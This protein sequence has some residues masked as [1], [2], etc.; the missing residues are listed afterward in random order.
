MKHFDGFEAFDPPAAGSVVMVGNFDGV[1]RGHRRLVDAARRRA[2]R[3]AVPVVAV[4]FEPHPLSIIAPNRAPARLSTRDEKLTLLARCGV[5]ATIVLESDAAL[6]ARSALDFLDELVRRSRPR[7]IVEGPTFNFGRGR[8]GSVETL[9]QNAAR[10]GY[11][12]EVVSE[13]YCDELEGRPDISSSAIR[14]ALTAAQ[15][16]RANAMLGRPYR[17][18]GTVGHGEHRG[19]ELGF[20]TANLDAVPHLLPGHA[21]YAAVAQLEDGRLHMAAVNIGPQPTFG[22]MTSRVEAH[23][24]DFDEPLR[25]ERLGLHLLERLRGQ[26]RFEGPAALVEQLTADVKRTRELRPALERIRDAGTWPL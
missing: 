2:A 18:V 17:I 14:A 25:R 26:V 3:Y 23:L 1:H 10:F 13:L 19:T 20:P 9:R 6:I 12:V 22:Q 7:T 5:D 11:E 21:V 15:I 8:E 16:E 24:L 4:T